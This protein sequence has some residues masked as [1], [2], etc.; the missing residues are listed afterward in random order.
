MRPSAAHHIPN[1][2][3]EYG[4][5][6][7]FQHKRVGATCQRCLSLAIR[8]HWGACTD[9]RIVSHLLRSL[10]PCRCLMDERYTSA[11]RLSVCPT[12]HMH[13]ALVCFQVHL[14]PH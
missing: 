8:L 4:W 3:Q 13:A 14:V 1:R 11:S 9:A 5:Q 2:R 7:V 12:T 10:H 6:V